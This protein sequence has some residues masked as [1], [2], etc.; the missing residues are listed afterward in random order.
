[1]AFAVWTLFGLMCAASVFWSV[2]THGHSPIKIAVFE[3]LVWYA[4]AVATPLVTW[5]GARAPII[6]FSLRG[7]VMHVAAAIVLGVAHAMWST[8]LVLVMRPFDSM[9][10]Q[11]FAGFGDGLRDR[12]FLEATVYFAILGVSYAVGYQRALREREIKAAQLEASLMQAQLTALELQ[13]QPHFLFN[14][15]HA[16]G[17]LVRQ[18]RGPE[19]IEMIAGLSDLLRYS[20]DHAGKQLVP[21]EQELAIVGRYLE[22]QRLRFSDRLA[23]HIEVPDTVRRGLVPALLLQPLVENAVRHGVERA[24]EP[25]TIDV[26]A[27]RD[28]DDLVLAVMNNGEAT[29]T[30]EGIGITN[31]RARLTQLFG[32]RHA[33]TLENEASRVVATVRLPF[34][35]TACAS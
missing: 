25:G 5:L 35:E 32:G 19:A 18:Q 3:L 12:L 33:F 4:W 26:R 34:V 8:L 16:I 30:S 17:G 21:L 28:G 24:S 20:L 13:L 10:I 14:T 2:R 22:I 15:L 1:M 11:S 23:V 27:S 29:A 31:T 7:T 6:P 9:S